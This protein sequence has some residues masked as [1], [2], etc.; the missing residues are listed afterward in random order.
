MKSEKSI[1]R[2]LLRLIKDHVIARDQ[3]FICSK[4][5]YITNDGDY[6]R[7]D[8]TEY[9]QKMFISTEIIKPNDISSG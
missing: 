5:G 2:A 8:V 6:P 7:V 1:G 4:N 3:V 9:M